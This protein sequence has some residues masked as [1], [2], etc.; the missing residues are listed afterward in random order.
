M[1]DK[2]AFRRGDFLDEV[3]DRARDARIGRHVAF[4]AERET[5]A[6]E[7][8]NF[9]IV[10]GYA[11]FFALW[12]GIASDLTVRMRCVTVAM[13]AVSLIVFIGWEILTM[14]VR[15]RSAAAFNKIS[16]D[17]EPNDDFDTQWDL[18]RAEAARIEHRY[19]AL[20]PWFLGTSVVTGMAAAAVLAGAAISRAIIG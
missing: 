2:L 14:V 20:W 11:A 9:V 15:G 10:A 13:M 8:T 3:R 12:S 5:K 6:K 7:Y 19:H 16:F 4:Q 1:D 17:V 18:A